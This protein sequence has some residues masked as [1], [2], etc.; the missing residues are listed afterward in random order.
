MTFVRIPLPIFPLLV[1]AVL[2]TVSPAKADIALSDWVITKGN[3]IEVLGPDPSVDLR[4]I[5]DGI[6]DA[7]ATNRYLVKLGP[8]VYDVGSGQALLLKEYVDLRGSGQASTEI[9]GSRTSGGGSCGS[10]SGQGVVAVPD[11]SVLSDLTV[12]NDST[13]SATGWVLCNALNSSPT[14]RRV[15][16]RSI[17]DAGSGSRHVIHL[18]GGSPELTDVTSIGESGD[19]TYGLYCSNGTPVVSRAWI[20]L[21]GGVSRNR[22]IW[23]VSSCVLEMSDLTLT[24]EES[25][26][27]VGIE[28]Q[29]DTEINLARAWIRVLG[30]GDNDGAV[31][32]DDAAA[33]LHDV[34]VRPAGGSTNIGLSLSDT[35]FLRFSRSTVSGS[36]G[37]IVY[38]S[39]D[40]GRVSQATVFS[41][42]SGTGT[43]VCVASDNGVGGVLASDCSVVP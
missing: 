3:T 34:R 1:C 21:S 36:S 2:T 4:E 9:V 43:L 12:T 42:V 28:V 38:D 39:T 26:I 19:N 10:I 7:S 8:G 30:S 37:G 27:N 24:V 33:I 11:N 32:R 6:L 18:E 17:A 15:T 35:A 22:G 5:L 29:N 20:S 31:A 25:P 41:G 40:D 13:S 14:I 16:A 23:L